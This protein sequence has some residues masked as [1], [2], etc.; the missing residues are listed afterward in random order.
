MDADPDV[1]H[2]V[3]LIAELAVL[4][5]SLKQLTSDIDGL[6]RHVSQEAKT[7]TTLE[8]DVDEA[9]E[10]LERVVR[11]QSS[12][13]ARG[14]SLDG[15]SGAEALAEMQHDREIVPRDAQA[16]L[17]AFN[18][19][20]WTA[21]IQRLEAAKTRAR[22]NYYVP[23]SSSWQ[24]PLMQQALRQGRSATVAQLRALRQ[25]AVAAFTANAAALARE[26]TPR[27]GSTPP[28]ELHRQWCLAALL[29]QPATSQ[30]AVDLAV[31][32]QAS[33]SAPVRESTFQSSFADAAAHFENLPRAV[34]VPESVYA[35]PDAGQPSSCEDILPP[36]KHVFAPRASARDAR[37]L[38][39]L[40]AAETAILG[41]RVRL[42]LK[43]QLR[44]LAAVSDGRLLRRHARLE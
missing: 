24:G 27:D 23:T 7:R 40:F 6:F 14:T 2:D 5:D 28:V 42:Q 37:E 4:R 10:S 30:I 29:T 26:A 20:S 25:R 43:H 39:D 18:D 36:A 1:A 11:H 13:A 33:V 21:R 35:W 3:R 22:Q 38:R 31:L 41:E 44:G 19:Q 34:R 9:A 8:R 12:R 17:A 32:A 15:V 16:A